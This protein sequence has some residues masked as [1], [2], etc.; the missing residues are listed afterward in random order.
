[1]QPSGIMKKSVSLSRICLV[2]C[3]I[4]LLATAIVTSTLGSL[5]PVFGFVALLAFIPLVKGSRAQKVV[6]AMVLAI[7]V[8]LLIF[9]FKDFKMQR[10]RLERMR[11]THIRHQ[12]FIVAKSGPSIQPHFS[13]A[14]R[15]LNTF[16]RYGSL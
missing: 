10:Q 6:A 16:N 1:M 15:S 3:I 12:I 8:T 4:I 9:S 2:V 5:L 14:F 7:A 13:L 11:K